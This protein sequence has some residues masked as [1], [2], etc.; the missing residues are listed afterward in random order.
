MCIRT[1]TILR[2]QRRGGLQL[3]A[4]IGLQSEEALTT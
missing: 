2:E 4:G 3:V 1:A